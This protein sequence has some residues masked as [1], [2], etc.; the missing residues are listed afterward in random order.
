MIAP[1]LPFGSTHKPSAIFSL[2]PLEPPDSS[3]G[4]VC[5]TMPSNGSTTRTA[6]SSHTHATEP[7]FSA[8]RNCASHALCAGAG[9]STACARHFFSRSHTNK[10]GLPPAV[11]TYRASGVMAMDWQSAGACSGERAPSGGASSCATS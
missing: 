8:G 1:Y 7:P 11:I 5:V 6:P 3:A 4:I 2:L 10:Q 9:S